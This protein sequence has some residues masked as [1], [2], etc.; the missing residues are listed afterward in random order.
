MTYEILRWDI[1][2]QMRVIYRIPIRRDLCC[3]TFLF[4]F[5]RRIPRLVLL[6]TRH[7]SL[8]CRNRCALGHVSQRNG[9]KVDTK[10]S[11]EIS[12]L[13]DELSGRTVL[14]KPNLRAFKIVPATHRLARQGKT[15][16]LTFCYYL[17]D[18]SGPHFLQ[19]STDL[20]WEVC[21][22]SIK[23][24]LFATNTQC[25]R[26]CSCH[27]INVVKLVRKSLQLITHTVSLVGI[28]LV[29][30]NSKSMGSH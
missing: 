12:R 18:L 15:G 8:D 16:N 29:Y 7:R 28:L 10:H 20:L 22:F 17:A 9:F 1:R 27:Y 3:L 11:D 5:Q 2:E 24:I 14:F 30:H 4:Q 25:N 21:P 26:I 13:P 6:R 19:S 23:R